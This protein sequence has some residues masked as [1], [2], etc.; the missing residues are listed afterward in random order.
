MEMTPS[1]AVPMTM[2]GYQVHHHHLHS[3]SLIVVDQE[4]VKMAALT[5]LERGSVDKLWDSVEF[6]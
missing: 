1:Q 5:L 4:E 3:D 2:S 6:R